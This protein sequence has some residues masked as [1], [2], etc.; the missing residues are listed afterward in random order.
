M[1]KSGLTSAGAGKWPIKT[2]VDE[3]EAPHIS[4]RESML[5]EFLD[6]EV[7]LASLPKA[8]S[9]YLRYCQFNE[10]DSSE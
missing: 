2:C 10:Y 5:P 3:N 4:A 1:T 7:D 9:I 8:V 6:D